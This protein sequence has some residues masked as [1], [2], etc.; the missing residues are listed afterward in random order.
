MILFFL[1][2]IQFHDTV[3]NTTQ[4]HS[5]KY[6]NFTWFPGV[7]SC[8]KT[9]FPQSF[10]RSTL[11]SAKLCVSTEFSL[12]EIRWNFCT[13]CSDYYYARILL[14]VTELLHW[15]SVS[16][17]TSKGVFFSIFSIENFQFVFTVKIFLS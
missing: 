7:E 3:R 4:M 9:Q 10:G 12:H 8:G 15:N 17:W 2:E 14:N 5:A 11:N 16:L 6:R 13:L 1:P